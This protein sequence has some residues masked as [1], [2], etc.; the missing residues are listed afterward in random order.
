MQERMK[1]FDNRECKVYFNDKIV[2]VGTKD[3]TTDLWVADLKNPTGRSCEHLDLHAPRDTLA[4]AAQNVY[5]IKTKQN[6][7]KY[8]H[9]AMCSPRQSTLLNAAKLN[10]LKEALQ[11]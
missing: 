1:I 4:H 5:S 6:A 9:Q 11:P 10:F 3:P 8:M 2:L 7:V